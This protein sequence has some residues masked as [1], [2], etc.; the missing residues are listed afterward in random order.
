MSTLFLY[1]RNTPFG[2]YGCETGLFFFW[3]DVGIGIPSM[4][5]YSVVTCHWKWINPPQMREKRH[6]TKFNT[7]R[8]KFHRLLSSRTR[9]IMLIVFPSAPYCSSVGFSNFRLTKTGREKSGRTCLNHLLFRDSHFH[10]R[11]E[12]LG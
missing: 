2:L 9:T 6:V 5:D 3:L 11:D 1:Q 12:G 10:R 4:G 7:S 8:R